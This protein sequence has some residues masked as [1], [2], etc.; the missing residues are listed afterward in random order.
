LDTLDLL[1]HEDTGNMSTCFHDSKM[2]KNGASVM[3]SVQTSLER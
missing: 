2:Q 1:S 3:S